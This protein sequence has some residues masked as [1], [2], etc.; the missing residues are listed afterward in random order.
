MDVER[1]GR[2]DGNRMNRLIVRA[3]E[4]AH[5]HQPAVVGVVHRADQRLHP[6]RV[7]QNVAMILRAGADALLHG[8]FRDPADVRGDFLDQLPPVHALGQAPCRV[9]PKNLRAQRLGNIHLFHHGLNLVGTKKVRAYRI[10]RN[11]KI[12]FFAMAADRLRQFRQ[13]G[14]RLNVQRQ[15]NKL[16]GVIAHL[17]G[18]IADGE[19]VRAGLVHVF[20]E[21]VGRYADFHLSHSPYLRMTSWPVAADS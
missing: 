14:R 20:G 9:M 6:L 21:A 7:L 19:I 5:V 3:E 15:V 4:V 1:I 12:D 13:A 11:G 16:D 17:F 10:G 2:G 8:V 18:Q